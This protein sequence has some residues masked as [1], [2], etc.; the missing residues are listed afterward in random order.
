MNKTKR[1]VEKAHRELYERS[2][3][4]QISEEEITSVIEDLIGYDDRTIDKYRKILELKSLPLLS[5]NL[6]A[7]EILYLQK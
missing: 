4:G 1:Q 7:Q 5:K 3:E 6:R 2:N